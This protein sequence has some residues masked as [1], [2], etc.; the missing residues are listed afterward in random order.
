MANNSETDKGLC[1]DEISGDLIKRELREVVRKLTGSGNV[2]LGIEPG[3]KK[4]KR[5]N[6]ETMIHRMN[7]KLFTF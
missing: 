4:G 7:T 1:I 6:N 5:F 3:S 2:E